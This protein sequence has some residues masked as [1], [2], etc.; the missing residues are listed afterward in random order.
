MRAFL[1]AAEH[2]WAITE[3]ALETILAIAQREN[4]N[5]EA[6]AAEL[7]RPLQNTHSVEMRGDVAVVPIV[8]PIFRYANLFTSISG[9]TSTEMVGLDFSTAVKNPMVRSIVLNIDSPGGEAAG[10]NE[11]A[12][13]VAG[14]RGVKPVTAYVGALAASGAYWIASAAESIVIDPTA[15]LGSIGVVTAV[16]KR[17][18]KPGEKRYAFVSSQS[19]LKQADPET[20]EGKASIQSYVDRFAAE[21]IASVAQ[22]RGVSVDKVA[23]DFGRGDILVG[24][25]AIKA[26]MADRLGSLESVIAEQRSK[27]VSF[28]GGTAAKSQTERKPMSEAVTAAVETAPVPVV[29]VSKIRMEAAQTERARIQAIIGCEE[30]K[31]REELAQTI[32]FETESTPEAAKKLLGSAKKEDPKKNYLAAAIPANPPVGVSPEN[33]EPSARSVAARILAIAGH[34]PRKAAI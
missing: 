26:G 1:Y 2:P 24:T 19:P 29:D 21:F 28:Y 25:D 23:T 17:D 34:G 18:A 10:I 11:L 6:V 7:G 12:G 8:G 32:A 30:A 20:D 14:A 15:A 33:E 31:G 4:L 13:M 27:T 5:P 3:G 22:H 16:T 9:A